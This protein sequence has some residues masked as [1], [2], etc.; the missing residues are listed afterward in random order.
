MQELISTISSESEF[1]EFVDT[2]T[3]P[4]QLTELLREDHPVYDQRGTATVVL[5]RGWVLLG[6]ARIGVT[7]RSIVYVLEELDT[8]VDPYLVAAAA[9]AL[10]SYS[11]PNPMLAPFVMRALNQV[12]YHDAPVSF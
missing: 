2:L 7:D 3:D 4:E 5:M 10:R 8:G 9:Y 11:K 12:R 6:L 1:A